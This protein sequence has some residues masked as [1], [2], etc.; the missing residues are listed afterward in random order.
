MSSPVRLSTTG[1]FSFPL[2]A[3]VLAR[4]PKN[5]AL[6]RWDEQS[7]T[8]RRA[9]VA[10]SG[11]SEVI[12]VTGDEGG[13]NVSSDDPL[14]LEWARASFGLGLDP[15]AFYEVAAQ[16]EV[17]AACVTKLWGL[18]PPLMEFWEAWVAAILG[19]QITLSFCLDTIGYTARRYGGEVS[20]VDAHGAPYAYPLHPSPESILAADPAELYLCKLSRQKIAYLKIVAAALLDGYFDG[21]LELPLQEAITKL[22]AL[23]GVGN[24]TARYWLSTVGRLDS[25]AYGDAG[26]ASAYRKAYGRTHDLEAWGEALGETRGWAYYYLIWGVKYGAGSEARSAEGKVK[27]RS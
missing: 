25:L 24:W 18:R 17:L 20:G 9:L 26:L 3:E 4:L 5:N 2:T 23:K 15:T 10:S 6:E 22:V 14:I 27:V 7:A 12:I 19:Q 21:V 11:H 1:P 8:H 13:I 16:D